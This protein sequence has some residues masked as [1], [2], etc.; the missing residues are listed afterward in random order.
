MTT[1][2]EYSYFIH[3]NMLQEW[4]MK[5]G[6]GYVLIYA[7]NGLKKFGVWTKSGPS[8]H[9]I[10]KEMSEYDLKNFSKWIR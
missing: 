8:K 3:D 5:R 1:D 6:Y 7:K 4:F 10:I 2:T 9:E